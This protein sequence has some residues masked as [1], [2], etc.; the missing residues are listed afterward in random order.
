MTAS[1]SPQ[2]QWREDWGVPV[3]EAAL[4]PERRIVDPHHHFWTWRAASAMAPAGAYLAG[5]LRDDLRGG[6]NVV[7]TVAIECGAAYRHELG[8]DLASVGETAFFAKEARRLAEIDPSFRAAGIVAH[9]DLRS[10]ED[11]RR[12]LAAHREAGGGLLRGVR[13][14]AGYDPD[15]PINISPVKGDLY[16]DP[17]FRAGARAAAAEGMVVDVWHYHSQGEA[18]AA[19]VRAC[20]EVTFVVDHYGTPL[21]AGAYANREQEIFGVWAQGIDLLAAHPNVLFKLGGFAL[22]MTGADFQLRAEQPTSEQVAARAKPYF[23]HVLNAAGPGRC[24]FESNFPI[25]KP[26]VSYTVLWNAFK[27]LSSGLSEG[28]ADDLFFKVANDAY[29]L[30]LT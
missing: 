3:R 11:V 16:A 5:D 22:S 6:H 30:E 26:C 13:Q 7:A 14:M 15:A 24:M 27:R 20:P 25:E 21:G 8:P 19:L 12:R 23:D 4:D 29:R 9:V 10:G 18:F 2:A 17:G 1:D 28:E